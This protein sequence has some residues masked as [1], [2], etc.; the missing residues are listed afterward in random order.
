MTRTIRRPL[1]T[2]A[3]LLSAFVLAACGSG[4]SRVDS[5]AIVGDRSVGLDEVQSEIRWLIDNVDQAEQAQQQG[6]LAQFGREVVRS[7]VVHELVEIAARRERLR[8]DPAEV[9]RLIQ[10]NGGRETIATT[11][12]AEPGR[13]RQVV[14][15]QLL[16][17]QL[18]ETYRDR[19]SV[20][21]VGTLVTESN[22][23]ATAE[24]TARELGE[25][26]AADPDAAE[27]MLRED[28]HQVLNETFALGE[29]LQQDPELAMSAVFGAD[30]GTVVVVQPSRQQTGWL[31]ALVAE[32]TF[33]PSTGRDTAVTDP[34]AAQASNPELLYR[35]GMRQ[36][37]PIA[38]ELGV[39]INPR[40]GVWDAVGMAPAP[41]EEE[42]TGYQWESRTVQP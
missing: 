42:L 5:A 35:A 36:L 22:A 6:K 29:T 12:L 7:R 31:V 13:V 32:R 40:Y 18:A 28:G 21:I 26:I 27:A 10:A 20:D 14:R 17:Q 3:V 9:D 1:A 41:S 19:L 39:R 23:Q 11:V 37:Q 30:E 16:L 2:V 25:R 15:D 34:A 4:P 38:D 33:G 24:D 8:V